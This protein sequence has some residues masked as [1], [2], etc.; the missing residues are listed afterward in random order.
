MRLVPYHCVQTDNIDKLWSSHGFIWPFQGK[1]CFF[2]RQTAS[3]PKCIFPNCFNTVPGVIFQ[4]LTNLNTKQ[5]KHFFS[6]SANL[7]KW[8]ICSSPCFSQFLFDRFWFHCCYFCVHEHFMQS[9]NEKPDMFKSNYC[10]WNS[11]YIS[12]MKPFKKSRNCFTY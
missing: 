12:F 3:G 1:M 4:L 2:I 9:M 11:V 6:K 10:L 7:F 5:K 8:D